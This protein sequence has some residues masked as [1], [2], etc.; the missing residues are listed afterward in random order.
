MSRADDWQEQ[1]PEPASGTP[2]AFCLVSSAL[3]SFICTRSSAVIG[4]RISMASKADRANQNP[5]HGEGY[6]AVLVVV[7]HLV[8][9][10]VPT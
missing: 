9:W 10:V 6:F 1:F 3:R 5:L 7:V 2:T 8:E 4:L